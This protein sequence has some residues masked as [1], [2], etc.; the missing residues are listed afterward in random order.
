LRSSI[1]IR[2]TRPDANYSTLGVLRPMSEIVYKVVRTAEWAT[3]HEEGV[4]KGS[5]D[6]ECDGF[7]HL[8]RAVQLRTTLEKH[9]AGEDGLLLVSLDVDGLGPELKWEP[10]RGGERFPHLYGPL[11]L[12]LAHSVVPIHRDNDGRPILPADLR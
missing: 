5:T 12:T 7:I 11:K 3:A 1:A 6:D 10:S 9:F 4:F 2:D 8:S